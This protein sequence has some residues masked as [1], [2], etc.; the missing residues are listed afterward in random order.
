M[1]ERG[2]G[3][4]LSHPGKTIRLV[5]ATALI[6]FS[7][8]SLFSPVQSDIRV[9]VVDKVPRE[10]PQR[11]RHPA[12]LLLLPPSINPIYDTIRMAYRTEPHQVGFYR[13]HQWGATP[14][15]ML[16]PLLAR[17][18]ENTHY[19]DAVATPP[20]FGPHSYALQ[21]TILDFVQDYTS[22][23][24]TFQLSLR[25]QLIEGTSNRIVASRTISLREPILQES[26]AAGVV[27]ANQAAASALQQA[28]QFVLER[29]P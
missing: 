16:L 26:P 1:S 4:A 15:Q 12:T 21:T 5:V 6:F 13:H 27:A 22:T 23:P 28:T 29:M 20:Y 24:A 14:A 11:Q 10:V 25:V 18:L 3:R 8:C 17:T 2:Y 9:S 7:G 19:F